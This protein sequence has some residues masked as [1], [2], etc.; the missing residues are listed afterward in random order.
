MG[1]K[2]ETAMQKSVPA[3]PLTRRQ[4]KAKGLAALILYMGF[5][6]LFLLP[7][8]YFLPEF[9]NI[10]LLLPLASL[11]LSMAAGFLPGKRRKTGFLLAILLQALLCALAL[12]PINPLSA[13]LF[14]PCLVMMLLFMPALSRPA[15]LEWS[16]SHLSQGIVLHLTGQAVKNLPILMNVGNT[17][18]LFF[19]FYLILCL[20]AFNRY[21][22]L[23]AS[24][25]E[26]SPPARLLRKNRRILGIFAMIALIFA[27]LNSFETAVL[28]AWEFLKRAI[29]S[30]LLWLSMLLPQLSSSRE[31]GTP[32]GFDPGLFG[33]ASEPSTFS[34]ILEKM[35][36]VVAF[37]AAS[38]LLLFGVYQ[39]FRLF[40][41]LV[42]NLLSRIME[43]SRAIGEGYVEKTESLLDWGEVIKS[44]RDK[45][46]SFQKR[47]KKPPSWES[48][49]PR[50]KVRHVYVLLMKR[51]KSPAPS[52]TARES[53]Q[54]AGLSLPP[55]KAL[56]IAS[57]YERARY[58]DH[59]ISPEE[60][61]A[62]RKSAGV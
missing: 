55:I 51:V 58:S 15:G 6:P 5:S 29:A 9:P 21:A 62:M 35:L 46:E 16:T 34:L 18:S 8:T 14:L 39:L 20:F 3:R 30:I 53:L 22:L 27:N 40:R 44:A 60:A 33:E 11:L 28:A 47:Y 1:N 49:P 57:L 37:I 7:G 13:L 12:L 10:I 61:D 36:I 38:L 24:R 56:K 19:S 48:L 4:F 41:R 43:Y 45:W 52:L 59:P 42:K 50:D 23:D 54:N 2:M 17:L 25:A 31:Q 26:Q 32:Q